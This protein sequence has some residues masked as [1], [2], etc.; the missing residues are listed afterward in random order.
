MPRLKSCRRIANLPNVAYFKPQGIPMRHLEEII[1]ELDELEA[2]RWADQEGYYQ[3]EAAKKM[4]VSRQTF[5]RI[6]SS[7]RHKVATALIKGCALRIEGG[8]V[9]Y[10]HEKLA[11]NKIF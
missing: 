3:A 1:L 8:N 6:V 4:Q 7:A 2:L 10:A 11:T 9:D 5:G